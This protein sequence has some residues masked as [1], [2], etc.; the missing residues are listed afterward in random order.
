MHPE[1]DR[2][3]LDI[4]HCFYNI[5]RHF[6]RWL[7]AF[8]TL[9]KLQVHLS[10]RMLT[11]TDRMTCYFKKYILFLHAYMYICEWQNSCKCIKIPHISRPA[12]NSWLRCQGKSLFKVYS[13]KIMQ[14]LKKVWIFFSHFEGLIGETTTCTF[15]IEQLLKMESKLH[16][17]GLTCWFSTTVADLAAVWV[18]CWTETNAVDPWIWLERTSLQCR[19]WAVEGGVLYIVSQVLLIAMAR[20]RHFMV[21]RDSSILPEGDC[22]QRPSG[23]YKLLT[24]ELLD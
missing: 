3:S 19:S 6:S 4:A 8:S 11:K 7:V 12:Q 9:I 17:I 13:F 23:W 22:C 24:A 16:D 20:Y 21:V 18:D 5:A 15:W 1:L 10:V 14:P 2:R